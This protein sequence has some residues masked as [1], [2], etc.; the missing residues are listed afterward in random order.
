[1]LLYDKYPLE[2]HLD[3]VYHRVERGGKFVSRC[4][5]DLTGDEQTEYLHRLDNEALKRL[6]RL[7]AANLRTVGDRF[8]IFGMGK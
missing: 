8:D 2:R 7:L 6:C 3:G 4:F 5:S 1:M